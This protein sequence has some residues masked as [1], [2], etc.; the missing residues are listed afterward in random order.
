[1]K[2]QTAVELLIQEIEK[3]QTTKAKS[4]SEWNEVFN[5]ARQIEKQKVQ[6]LKFHTGTWGMQDHEKFINYCNENE[7]E[8]IN[9]WITYHRDP[10]NSHKP[11]SINY[12]V[13]CNDIK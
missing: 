10:S 11:E 9:S 8:F 13:R 5:K 2:K 12:V 1:M 6:H 4:K 3:D 7:V